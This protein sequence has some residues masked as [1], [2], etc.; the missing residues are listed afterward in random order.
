MCLSPY[1][2][3]VWNWTR[4]TELKSSLMI[5]LR[6]T[7]SNTVKS[8]WNL[9]YEFRMCSIKWKLKFCSVACVIVF[10]CKQIPK[11][12]IKKCYTL[13]NCLLTV[14]NDPSPSIQAWM[15]SIVFYMIFIIFL[16]TFLFFIL[17][18]IP[19]SSCILCANMKSNYYLRLFIYL[20]IHLCATGSLCVRVFLSSSSPIRWLS[21]C[22]STGNMIVAYLF[23]Y[24]YVWN[25]KTY[26]KQLLCGF[27]W[28]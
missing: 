10:V 25:G 21:L 20:F 26:L 22:G 28:T 7:T 9:Q 1:I 18:L 5:I 24:M 14:A 17:S 3:S 4:L 16:K 15:C 2:R 6:F 27:S 11:L 19:L 8:F 13:T 12:T 23:T